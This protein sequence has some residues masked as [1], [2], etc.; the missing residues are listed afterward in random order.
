MRV[1]SFVAL[2]ALAFAGQAQEAA[3]V[4]GMVT[5]S[6][7]GAPI[8]R[9]HVKLSGRQSFGA[10]TNGE[11]KY[12]ITGIPPG[13]Y[14]YSAERV[15][16]ISEVH[17]GSMPG[18][19]LHAGDNSLDMTLIPVGAVAGKV[20]DAEGEPVQSVRVTAI[21]GNDDFSST[22]DSKGNFELAASHRGGTASKFSR[23]VRRRR[24][25]PTARSKSTMGRPIIRA[26]QPPKARLGL[27]S[28]RGAK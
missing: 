6:V 26:F 14:G 10:L 16:F 22:T 25:A 12:S 28:R 4:T 20:L 24:S 11:G 13:G 18:Q 19:D 8:V 1:S 15:G 23:E 3:S 7:T 21:G 2:V 17:M 27:P 9:A 5:N